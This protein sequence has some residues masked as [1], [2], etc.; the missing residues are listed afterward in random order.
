MGGVSIRFND[1]SKVITYLLLGYNHVYCM[2]ALVA[3]R[4]VT[5]VH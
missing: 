5:H 4:R 2:L 3:S 1:N